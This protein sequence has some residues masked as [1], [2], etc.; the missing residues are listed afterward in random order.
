MVE[1]ETWLFYSTAP[2]AGDNVKLR[3]IFQ[4]VKYAATLAVK[5][6]EC[7]SLPDRSI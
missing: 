5:S 2:P 6:S 4:G 3:P 1:S 7:R